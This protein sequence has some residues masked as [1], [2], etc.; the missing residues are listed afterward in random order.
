MRILK[1]D[2]SGQPDKWISRDDAIIY[3]AK[4]MVAWQLGEGDNDVC[5]R[6]GINRITG[7]QSQIETGP[8]IAVRG[9]SGA[10]KRA[11]KVPSLSNRALFVRDH[12]ICAYCAK[13]FGDAGLSRDHV[14]PTSRGG[15]DKW[16]NVVT[17]CNNCNHRKDDRL[18]QECGMQLLYVPYA[19]NMAESLIL[20]NRNVLAS[21][22]EYLKE[23]LPAHSRVWQIIN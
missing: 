20:E 11:K 9:E 7:K 4:G 10:A 3:H 1:L 21:Q 13:K 18:L 2:V 16:T 6:G 22:M 8:I 17:A 19:P 15:E 5:Y 14:I 23:F 12:H